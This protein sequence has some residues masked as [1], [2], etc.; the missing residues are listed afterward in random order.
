MS[1]AQIID[2]LTQQELDD[3]RAVAAKR[4][5][6]DERKKPG[7]KLKEPVTFWNAKYPFEKIYDDT[8]DAPVRFGLGTFVATTEE[9]AAVCRRYNHIYEGFTMNPPR[10]CDVCTK[11]FHNLDYFLDHRKGHA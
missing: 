2:G 1:T 9:Q 4:R 10:K 7:T 8:L 11:E 3:I 6:A 5:K